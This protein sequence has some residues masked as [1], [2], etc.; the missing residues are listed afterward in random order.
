MSY[1]PN[2]ALERFYSLKHSGSEECKEV[3]LKNFLD[4]EKNI[5]KVYPLGSYTS[6]KEI[7]TDQNEILILFN[8]KTAIKLKGFSDYDYGNEAS[9]LEV[10]TSKTNKGLASLIG[11]YDCKK[12]QQEL[13]EYEALYKEYIADYNDHFKN[14][15]VDRIF[16]NEIFLTKIKNRLLLTKEL[17]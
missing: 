14:N 6:D 12:F 17:I 4:M 2:K 5:E 7:I 13:L 1:Y 16:K 8:D 9:Y 10:E 15:E 3:F 11:L